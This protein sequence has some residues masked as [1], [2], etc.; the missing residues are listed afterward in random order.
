MAYWCVND[1]IIIIGL[2]DI[3][4]IIDAVLMM[5]YWLLTDIDDDAW[6]WPDTVPSTD[7]YDDDDIIIDDTLLWYYYYWCCVMMMMI[8]IVVPLLKC[9]ENVCYYPV[10]IPWPVWLLILILLMIW[11]WWCYYCYY[12]ISID[13]D[14]ID[15]IIIDDQYYYSCLIIDGCIIVWPS[16]DMWHYY[17][18]GSYY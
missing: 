18:W 5:F 12:A 11:Y 7:K 9:C 1:I 8:F 14:I 6:R 17:Y 16:I 13:I 15:I 10:M 3:I 4:S 2:I